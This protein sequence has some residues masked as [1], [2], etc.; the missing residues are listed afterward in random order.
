MTYTPYV[1]LY[2]G[3]TCEDVYAEQDDRQ[4]LD[5]EQLAAPQCWFV[6]LTYSDELV[7]EL[8]TE[9]W[10]SIEEL[11][12][13]GDEDEPGLFPVTLDSLRVVTSASVCKRPKGFEG[14]LPVKEVIVLDYYRP[15]TYNTIE[16]LMK[17]VV[18][19]RRTRSA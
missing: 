2:S 13:D 7:R 9:M 18:Q 17:I 1:Y 6:A 8:A 12:Q 11:Y 14:P 10:E 5:L 4:D 16:P 19:V 15:P 3:A